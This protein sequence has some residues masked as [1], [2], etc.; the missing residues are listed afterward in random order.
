MTTEE[1]RTL[2]SNLTVDAR[3]TACPGFGVP[4]A[5]FLATRLLV[6]IIVR[7][8]ARPV[9]AL[10]TILTLIRIVPVTCAQ[11]V[12]TASECPHNQR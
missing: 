2:K 4:R 8:H 7:I 9:L 3:G 12:A 6:R 11:Y 1:L 5:A 10:L